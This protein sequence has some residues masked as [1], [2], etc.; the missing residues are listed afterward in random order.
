MRPCLYPNQTHMH[1][2]NPMT[3]S[4]MLIP[5]IPVYLC[6]NLIYGRHSETMG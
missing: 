4:S 6:G 2:G 1:A 5:F 3:K